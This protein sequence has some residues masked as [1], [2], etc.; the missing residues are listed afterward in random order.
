MTTEQAQQSQPT[1]QHEV[2]EATRHAVAR[3]ASSVVPRA[4][5]DDLVA[6]VY[7]MMIKRWQDLQP[8]YLGWLIVTTKNLARN[9]NRLSSKRRSD[10]FEIW[11]QESRDVPAA[12]LSNR[13]ELQEII[14]DALL[15][16]SP[17]YR[18]ALVLFTLEDL[19]VDEC[20]RIAGTT[21]GNFKV[22][23][24]RARQQMRQIL[25]NSDINYEG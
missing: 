10:S 21:P 9:Q 23:L 16:L 19:S 20:A 12:N 14:R 18:E 6:D 3:Y 22:R 25:A 17:K 5:V 8:P 11:S 24:H 15:R 1:T 13:S 7:V 2:Y 4:D